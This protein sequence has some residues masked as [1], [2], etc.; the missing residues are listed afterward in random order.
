MTCIDCDEQE[1]IIP[2][3][4]QLQDLI[5]MHVASQA[6]RLLPEEIRFLRTHLGFSG[7]QFAELLKVNGAT[8]S[9]WENGKEKI[10]SANELAL[11][12]LILGRT[13]PIR[14]YE[15]IKGFGKNKKKTPMRRLFVKK[16]SVWQEAA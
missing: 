12:L 6:Y 7:S 9:R 15:E 2:H 1:V 11:R 13:G 14:E 3:V 4:E 10:G 16:R 8:I 5:A